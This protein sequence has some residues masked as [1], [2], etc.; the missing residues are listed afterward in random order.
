MSAKSSLASSLG[1]SEGDEGWGWGEGAG[2]WGWGRKM[3]F[4]G[5]Q[6]GNLLE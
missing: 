4:L 3:H 2:G 6:L 1:P 5:N